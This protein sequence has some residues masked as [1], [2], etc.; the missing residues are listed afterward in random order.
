MW[1][2]WENMRNAYNILAKNPEGKRL[3][4]IP[5]SRWENNIKMDLKI[6]GGGG[7]ESFI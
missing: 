4:E 2:A 1:H 6:H 3:F 5:A 7:L